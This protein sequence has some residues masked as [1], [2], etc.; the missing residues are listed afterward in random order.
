MAV[1]FSDMLRNHLVA[2][3]VQIESVLVDKFSLNDIAFEAGYYNLKR[4]WNWGIVGAQIPYFSSVIDSTATIGDPA[5]VAL[6]LVYRQTQRT[7]SGV[8]SY[9]FNRAKRVE[10]HGGIAHTAFD[11]MT[12]PIGFSSLTGVT[13]DSPVERRPVPSQTLATSTV[14]LVFDSASVGPTS[15]VLGQ[16]YRF[17]VSPTFGSMNFTGVLIDYRKYA[18]PVPFYTI[19]ARL[20]HYGRYGRD[21]DDARQYP[22]YINHPSLVRGYDD[23]GYALDCDIAQEDCDRNASLVGSR[24]LVANLE[25]RFP[26]LRPF[27]VSSNMYGPAAMELAIFGDAGVAWTARDKPTL[28]GGSRNGVSS[29]G[30]ALRLGLGVAVAEFNVTRPFQRPDDSWVW[31]FNLFPGW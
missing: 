14:A 19:A 26:V 11:Q 1:Y 4:R 28:V 29:A 21:S 10:F 9:P 18:M 15:P 3:A 5:A 22:V 13:S 25:L 17:E 16:R 27:G 31:G 24:M 8:V 20:L 6:P 23:P 7:V 2:A 30:V 12:N